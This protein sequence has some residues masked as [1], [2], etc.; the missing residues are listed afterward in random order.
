LERRGVDAEQLSRGGVREQD[1]VR[2]VQRDVW[3]RLRERVE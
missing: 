3:Q 2:V 1:R